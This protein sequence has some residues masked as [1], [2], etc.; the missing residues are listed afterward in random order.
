MNLYI[1]IRISVPFQLKLAYTIY[2]CGSFLIL[3]MCPGK[4]SA[5]FAVQ[6]RNPYF[7]N[8]KCMAVNTR[9]TALKCISSCEVFIPAW[10]SSKSSS[11][12]LSRET[13]QSHLLT[14]TRLWWNGE[15]KMQ[16]Q[17]KRLRQG[18]GGLTRQIW[19]QAKDRL[20]SGEQNQ[21]NLNHKTPI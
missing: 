1:S 16:Q 10:G 5:C 8:Q 3:F 20:C 19:S 13:A 12:G 21:F 9:H 18:Q 6:C 14:S 4:L 7:W 11:H 15:E 17:A 2:V